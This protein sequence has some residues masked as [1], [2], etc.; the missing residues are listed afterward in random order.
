MAAPFRETKAWDLETFLIERERPAPEP[1]CLSWYDGRRGAVI[2]HG[3]ALRD[4]IGRQLEDP[5]VR[6]VGH[7]VA[8][9]CAVVLARYPELGPALFATLEAGRI[10]DTMVRQQLFFIAQRPSFD[11]S[12]PA[13]GLAQLVRLIFDRDI[14]AGKGPDAWR[15]RY[16][17]L[18]GTAFDTWPQ[19]ALDYPLS[20][21]R[22]TWLCW[23]E[24]E[25]KAGDRIRDDAFMTYAA[26]CL[27][28]MS[29]RG[30]RTDPAAV[31]RLEAFWTAEIERLRP[32]LLSGG[33][34]AYEGPKKDPRRHLK[35]KTKPA[36]A[37]M[38]QAWAA[39]HARQDAAG[40]D[41]IAPYLT[42]SAEKRKRAAKRDGGAPFEPT[43]ADLSIDKA[44][45]VITGD[46]LMLDRA[47]YVL[48]EKI[49]STY[50]PPMRAGTVGPLSTRFNLAST[51]RTTSS[52]PREP[53]IGTN[54]QN[55]P[56]DGGVRECIVPR[57]GHALLM[58]DLSSAELH[59]LAE[60]CKR[61]VGYSTLGDLLLSGEDAHLYLACKL[62]GIAFNDDAK[63]RKRDGDPIIL[64]ARQRAKPGNFGFGGAMGWVKFILYNLRQ[65]SLYKNGSPAVDAQV[66]APA[67]ARALRAAW[68]EAYPEMAEYFEACKRELGPAESCVI[69]LWPG[70]P[71]RR[72]KGLS[73]IANSKFQAPAARGAKM[74]VTAITREAHVGRL[75]RLYPVNFVHDEVVGELEISKNM[76][77]DACFAAKLMQDEFNK[78]VPTYPTKVEPVLATCYSKK[79]EPTFDAAGRLIPWEPT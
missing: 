38:A 40:D 2:P 20:D 34:L 18:Y 24:Q 13:Y 21:A 68:L 79:A 26:F 74:G 16:G 41:R 52:A 54:L 17:E 50:V 76:H 19:E 22:E 66:F 44:A 61:V 3:P 27:Y 4:W 33:L 78:M 48:A 46:A 14:S 37:R 36:R 71:L 15:Y 70:G 25:T 55:A 67:E 64:A 35:K 56:R 9:D 43:E 12:V 51:M 7:N 31:D 5:G 1:V 59:T 47:R 69:E 49:L 77:E 45:C 53:V 42:D 39:L 10:T 75:R 11:D 60:V 6:L 65:A 8:Y 23:N 28:L 62:L 73:M 29:C 30:M 32:V 63:A 72:V 58:M 57:P